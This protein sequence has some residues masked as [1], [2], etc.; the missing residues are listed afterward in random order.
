MRGDCVAG[1]AE[2]EAASRKDGLIRGRTEVQ[3]SRSQSPVIAASGLGAFAVIA[4]GVL[5]STDDGQTWS[6]ADSGLEDVSIRHL[7][8]GRGVTIA[9]NESSVYVWNESGSRWANTDPDPLVNGD[10][11][12]R[13]HSTRGVAVD[14]AG[15]FIVWG[16][17]SSEIF[18]SED[19]GRSWAHLTLP[20]ADVGGSMSRAADGALFYEAGQQKVLRSSDGGRN[21]TTTALDP[22]LSASEGVVGLPGGRF[23]APGSHSVQVGSDGRAL[24]PD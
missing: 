22:S 15:A 24:T 14:D 1:L 11:H 21:W 10:R 20:V 5:R 19:G 4:S 2:L 18:R 7:A 17:W 8:S 13:P 9:S 23:I 16:E 6:G 3:R 12:D